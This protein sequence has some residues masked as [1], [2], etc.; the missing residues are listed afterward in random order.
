VKAKTLL[1]I[2]AGLT[3][4]LLAVIV[5]ALLSA[6]W[7]LKSAVVATV[8]Q[9]TGFPFEIG[10]LRMGMLDGTLRV[11]GLKLGNPPGFGDQPMVSL[12]ELYLAYDL[13]AARTNSLRFREVRIN[14]DQLSMVIDAQG[15]TNLT[16]IAARLDKAGVGQSRPLPTNMLGGMTY[17]G[18]GRL[19]ISLGQVNLTDLRAGATSRTIVMGLTN[20]TFTNVVDLTPLVPLAFKVMAKT[21]FQLR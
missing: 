12:P 6:D 5:V 20:Q 7:V 1:K 2:L 17:G 4:L 13:E 11:Q 8:R 21:M 14:L 9:Q 19:E 18:I 10:Q 3:A 16:E 15:R